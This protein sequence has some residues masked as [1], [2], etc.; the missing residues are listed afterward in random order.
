M[1]S[2]F[3]ISQLLIVL[4]KF[5]HVLQ[6]ILP[7]DSKSSEL[8][9]LAFSPNLPHLHVSNSLIGKVKVKLVEIGRKAARL[10]AV[11]VSSKSKTNTIHDDIEV[12]ELW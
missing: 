5:R 3:G 1:P 12:F 2:F 8:V 4:S 9:I 6:R 10:I 11:T 7:R